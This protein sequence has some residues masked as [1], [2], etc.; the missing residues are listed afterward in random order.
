MKEDIKSLYEKDHLTQKDIIQLLL[1][2]AQHM[3]TRDELK[4]DNRELKEDLKEDINR[5]DKKIDDTKKEL[6]EDIESV[7]IELKEEI[8]NVK[9]ELKEDIEKL[10]KKIESV[11]TELKEDIASVRNEL[12]E[13]IANLKN[14]DI[15]RLDQRISNID[16]K[17]D[18]LQWF[19]IATLISVF[20]KDY[21]IEAL[22]KLFKG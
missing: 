3:V 21:I 11:R 13:D 10:D 15:V 19:I 2:N 8:V 16:K 4:A 14:V 12:K 5:L 18:R 22:T 1:H 7:R 17:F 9:S 6:K 20:A